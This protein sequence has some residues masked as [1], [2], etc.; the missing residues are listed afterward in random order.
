MKTPSSLL[1]GL[2]LTGGLLGAAEMV[3]LKLN[4]PRPLF[5]GTPKPIEVPNLDTASGPRPDFM[6]PAGTVNLSAGKP[7]TASDEFP[8]IGDVEYV[9]DG[10]KDGEDGYFVELGPDLQWVQIDL[11]QSATLYAVAVWHYH[12]QPRVYLDVVIQLSD[13]PEFKKGVTT[14]YNNDHDNSAGMGKGADL[15]WIESNEGRIIDA[16]GTKA[17]YVRLYSGGNTSDSMNHYIE[18]EVYGKP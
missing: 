11:E 6:V 5:P 18:V 13:D 12:K 1:I 17:R 9:T 10:D 15:A 3:P 8:V 16:K 14:L 2:L 4:P 7:V